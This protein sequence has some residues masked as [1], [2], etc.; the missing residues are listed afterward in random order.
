MHV[1]GDSSLESPEHA[2]YDML[3]KTDS[4]ILYQIIWKKQKKGSEKANSK[5]G[6][7]THATKCN[8]KKQ[9]TKRTFKKKPQEKS[10]NTLKSNFFCCFC[11]LLFSEKMQKHARKKIRTKQQHR[12]KKQSVLCIF[13]CVLHL[14][15]SYLP[16]FVF[17]PKSDFLESF[18]FAFFCFSSKGWFI[19]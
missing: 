2:I 11:S 8:W 7:P 10:K 3:M 18:W 4:F 17:F 1:R 6:H 19:E 12:Q 13:H 14:Y 16:F 15:F 9:K 5:L